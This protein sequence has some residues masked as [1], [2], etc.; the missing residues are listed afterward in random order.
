M[1]KN[2][3]RSRTEEPDQKSLK[4]QKAS[5]KLSKFT[6]SSLLHSSYSHPVLRA[7]QN[8]ETRTLNKSSLIYPIFIN[9][10]EGNV[11]DPIASLPGISRY[12]V[13]SL[14][15]EFTPLVEKGLKTVLIFGVPVNAKK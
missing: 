8:T 1:S 2:A 7:W 12:S 5:P 4:V 9:D 11:L 15:S 10:A 14:K 6:V 3:K 13:G